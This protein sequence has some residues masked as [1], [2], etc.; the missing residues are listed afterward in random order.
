M[1]EEAGG[2]AGETAHRGK[3]KVGGNQ[4]VVDVGG[5]YLASDGSMVAGWACVLENGPS[6]G[7]EPDETKD[8]SV[9][10]GMGCAVVVQGYEVFVEGGDFGEMKGRG[11]CVANGNNSGG[12][13][14]GGGDEIVVW[15]G[16]VGRRAKRANI[17]DGPLKFSAAAIF[18]H[19]VGGG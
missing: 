1:E 17:D 7:G 10:G 8:S 5:V 11:R 19:F 13:E 14:S 15:G 6:I 2:F 9:Q 12:E 4:E 16:R 18:C 3:D